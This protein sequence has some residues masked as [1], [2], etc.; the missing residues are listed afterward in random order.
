M[1][2][3][4]HDK[5]IEE[6]RTLLLKTIVKYCMNSE[7]KVDMTLVLKAMAD[8]MAGQ[9]AIITEGWPE[10]HTA[11][12]V[13]GFVSYIAHMVKECKELPNPTEELDNTIKELL[14]EKEDL[15]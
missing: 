1:D 7:E 8:V 11:E 4:K 13:D 15:N 6:V 3:E 12:A 9:L 2:K 14:A 10:E 5:V